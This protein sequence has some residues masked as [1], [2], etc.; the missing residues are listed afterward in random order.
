MVN[1]S[2][3]KCQTVLPVREDKIGKSNFV[4]PQC[5]HPLE[6]PASLGDALP[7]VPARRGTRSYVPLLGRRE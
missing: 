4:C 2:C 6:A 5:F 1:L 7:G 3:P